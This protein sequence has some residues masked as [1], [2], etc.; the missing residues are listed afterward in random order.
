M[1]RL[2]TLVFETP[3]RKKEQTCCCIVLLAATAL[4]Q[5]KLKRESGKLSKIATSKNYISP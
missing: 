5:E 3:L 1:E 4:V 2:K